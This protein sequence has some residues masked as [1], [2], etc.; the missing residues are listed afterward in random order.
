M[1]KTKSTYLALITVLLS[2]MAA[3][4]DP[5]GYNIS[6][7]GGG[8]Y[9]IA[10][11]FSFDESLLGTGVIDEGEVLSFMIEGFLNNVSVG[12]FDFFADGPLAGADQFNF[13]FDTILES[14]VVGGF[15]SGLMGQN[16][17]ASSGGSTCA[18]TGF[19]FSSGSGAQAVCVGGGIVSA[20]FIGIGSSTLASAR[21]VPEPGTLALLG[22]GLVGMGLTRRRKKV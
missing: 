6:W 17:G 5:I 3:N 19:G 2:P 21:K 11:M 15:S 13:N 12:T 18:T 7:T 1:T 14:F 16:W 20:S 9:T 22:I 10:G 4:A 8:G